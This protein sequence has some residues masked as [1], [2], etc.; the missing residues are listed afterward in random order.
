M[1]K[2]KSMLPGYS[3]I[4][5]V[6][7]VLS[8]NFLGKLRVHTHSIPVFLIPCFSFTVKYFANDRITPLAC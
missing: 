6:I 5:V 8:S 7:W 4:H 1:H 2:I 3:V